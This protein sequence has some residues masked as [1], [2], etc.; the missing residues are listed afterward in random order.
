MKNVNVKVTSNINLSFFR[1]DKLIFIEQ[2]TCLLII[3]FTNCLFVCSL[4][5]SVSDNSSLRWCSGSRPQPPNP[6]GLP[7]LSVLLP[8][9]HR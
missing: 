8:Q 4:F 1:Q 2:M 3:I 6:D 7:N 5:S 9:G